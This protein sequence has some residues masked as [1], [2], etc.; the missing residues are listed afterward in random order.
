MSLSRYDIGA[1]AIVLLFVALAVV[2]SIVGPLFEPPDEVFHY[3]YVKHLADGGGLPVQRPGED[4]MWEQEG[5]QPPLYYALAAAATF[6]INTDDLPSVRRINPHARRGIPLAQDNKNIVIHTAREDFPWQ[7]S[8]LAVHLIR[9]FSV[10]MAAGT[11]LCTYRLGLDLFPDRPLLALGAMA[12]NALIPTFLFVSSSVN[13]DNLVTLLSS[14]TLLLLVRVVQ[15]GLPRRLLILVGVLIGL[16]CLSKLSAL[17]LIPLAALALG[18]RHLLVLHGSSHSTPPLSVARDTAATKRRFWLEVGRWMADCVVVLAPAALVAGWWYARNWQLYGEPLGL[19]AML[20]VVGR[21]SEVPSLDKLFGEFRGFRISFWG[22]FGAVNV[23]LRPH[24]VYWILDGVSLLAIAGLA[25]AAWR[26]RRSPRWPPSFLSASWIAI[27]LVALARWTSATKASQGRLLFSAISPICLFLVLGLVECV[28]KRHALY[29]LGALLGLML[30]LSATA[31]FAVI[32]PTY[33]LP[34][35]LTLDDVPASAQPFKATYG[36]VMRLLAHQVGKPEVRPGESV[37]VTL[38]WQALA[39]MGEDYS[40]YI[41]VFGKDGQRLGQRDSYPGGGKYPTSMWSAGDVVRDTFLVP[42]RSDAEGPVAA[43]IEVGLYRLEAMQNL[44]V[45][46][47]RGHAIGQ[48][49]IS[50]VKIAIPTQPV[51]PAHALDANLD[52]RVRLLGYDLET[53][54]ATPGTNLPIT[55]YW[56]VAGELEKDYTVFVHLLD[57]SQAIAGQGDGPPLEGS[58]PTSFWGVGET[59]TDQ[60]HL[61]VQEDA[62][63]GDYQIAVGLYDRTTMQRLRVLNADGQPTG[64][65]V[66]VATIQV[67][68]RSS[69]ANATPR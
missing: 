24:W 45:V 10:V 57:A 5:S 25:T 38:Y 16:A 13:N 39:P 11:I 14:V 15:R 34:P 3:P 43:K 9:L 6:W 60:H 51:E 66:V 12:F 2:Y 61:M 54:Q 56:Q 1:G 36:G 44:P 68:P 26:S 7:G 28:P 33:A 55:L 47:A 23:L 41:H 50:L 35:I 18:L 32:A 65:R 21:R 19:S 59:L 53:S 22:L 4:A 58:Y 31:P 17:G 52:N 30:F 62:P 8:V 20:D 49:V 67:V 46:D 40:I 69:M 63:P 27:V 64:D 42:I 48:P 29:G 37:P